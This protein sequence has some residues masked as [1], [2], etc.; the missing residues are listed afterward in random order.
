MQPLS[1]TTFFFPAVITVSCRTEYVS[2]NWVKLRVW[3]LVQYDA[4]LVVDLDV[5]FLGR[6]DHIMNLPTDF[7]AVLDEARGWNWT[8]ERCKFC[9][10]QNNNPAVCKMHAY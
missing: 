10:D 4:I 2:L 1:S 3:E 5:T 6:I 9:L 7:A 8:P